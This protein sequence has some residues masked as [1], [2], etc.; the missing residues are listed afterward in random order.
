M[1][2]PKEKYL[3]R[4]SDNVKYIL[5]E[6]IEQKSVVGKGPLALP[7]EAPV[8]IS[9]PTVNCGP[10]GHSPLDLNPFDPPPTSLSSSLLHSRVFPSLVL[11]P[12]GG[13]D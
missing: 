9:L 1:G 8:E 3:E 13:W 5:E 2:G 12:E 4:T 11:L 7:H 10:A 6:V